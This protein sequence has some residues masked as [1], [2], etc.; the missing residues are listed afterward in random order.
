VPAQQFRRLSAVGVSAYDD[1]IDPLEAPSMRASAVLCLPIVLWCTWAVHGG[2]DKKFP[3]P[4]PRKDAI[5]KRCVEEF[6]LL[7]PDGD[8]AFIMGTAKGGADNERPA[9]K[10]TLNHVFAISKY[11][12]TQELYHVVMGKN[13]ARWQGP[14]NS[15]EMVAWDDAMRFCERLTREL[16]ERKLIGAGETIRLPSE[17]E[18]EYACRA[19]TTTAFSFGDNVAD[20]G[21]YSWYKKNAPGNDPPVGVKKAN[22]LGLYDMHGYVSEW[23]LDAA[24][25]NYEGAP[26]DGSAWTDAKASE[27]VIRGGSFADEPDVQRCAARQFVP[28]DTRSDKIGFR[29]V[30]VK[31]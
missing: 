13:P 31:K 3:D 2:S 29:C 12:V 28:A 27:R 10:V 22:P 23:C 9:H 14:R 8:A 6:R 18:W 15:V 16:R 1:R 7:V 4:T 25:K 21:E 11:E 30:K 24:H 17:A 19:G 26:A 5:L 20:L